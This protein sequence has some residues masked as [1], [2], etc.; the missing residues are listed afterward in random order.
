MIFRSIVIERIALERIS[1]FERFSKD[2]TIPLETI[3]SEGRKTIAEFQKSDIRL[4]RA[5]MYRVRYL[6]SNAR[7][8][9]L[10]EEKKKL[11]RQIQYLRTTAWQY[12]TFLTLF[13]HFAPSTP[14]ETVQKYMEN[15]KKLNPSPVYAAFL[16]RQYTPYRNLYRFHKRVQ[17]EGKVPAFLRREAKFYQALL[18]KKF[19]LAASLKPDDPD[20]D[21]IILIMLDCRKRELN[22]IRIH[23][24]KAE[25][26]KLLKEILPQFEGDNEFAQIK[27]ALEE[28]VK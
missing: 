3:Q 7:V 28:T 18:A 23:K 13:C 15:Q 6:I 9:K 26:E 12:D 22:N 25:A 2:P 8:T 21:H 11:E 14:L 24:G 27:Q 20:L 1:S 4:R 10:N 16:K 5:V 19:A 17:E